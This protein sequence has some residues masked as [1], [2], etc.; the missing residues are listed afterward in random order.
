MWRCTEW[1]LG[2]APC[3][4]Q[5]PSCTARSPDSGSRL[6]LSATSPCPRLTTFHWNHP[7]PSVI[8]SSLL[9]GKCGG[10]VHCKS[11]I[12]S[13]HQSARSWDVHVAPHAPKIS[14]KRERAEAALRSLQVSRFI[15][16]EVLDS[17]PIGAQSIKHL[18]R[19]GHLAA[20][21]EVKADTSK[22]DEGNL[23]SIIHYLAVC[24]L[25]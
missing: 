7:R 11:K 13:S 17:R 1:T 9:R 18:Q 8:P 24:M 14:S 25:L 6:P 21:S 5:T 3:S 22:K 12:C 23:S 15:Q 2:S 20:A 4:E 10:S 16:V 19:F